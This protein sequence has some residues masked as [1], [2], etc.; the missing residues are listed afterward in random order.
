MGGRRARAR[1]SSLHVAIAGAGIGGLTAA[2]ALARIGCRVAVLEQAAAL[3]EAGA[4][5]QLAPNASRILARLG[6]LDRLGARAVAPERLL[7][8][9][10]SDASVL[11]QMRL[12][13]AAQARW[14]APFL[15]CHR[16]DL[17]TALL[18]AAG[19]AGVMLHLGAALTGL[20][21]DA[22]RVVASFKQGL[23]RQTVEAD[24]LIG[25]DGLH[26]FVR[27]RLAPGSA[28]PVSTRTAWRTLVPAADAPFFARALQSHL[29]LGRQAHLVHYPVR[30]GALV[31]V[32]AIVGE[33]GDAGDARGFWEQKGETFPAARF[34]GWHAGARDLLAAAAAWRKWPLFERPPLP[35]WNA[36]RVA[37]LGDAAHPMLPFLAQGA[38]Q[39]IE[40][41]AALAA[42]LGASRDVEAALAVYSRARSVRADRVQ[43]QSRRQGD[44]YHMAGPAALV[45]NLVLRLTGPERMAAQTD[46]LYARDAGM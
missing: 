7:I 20:A 9:K 17:Q 29:W 15:V 45:R 19:E 24:A 46:W 33:K 44:I 27:A 13:A 36:G 34:A 42:A 26:S 43:A 28:A 12:G 14:G 22:G 31:N 21:A 32:V 39:A 25:A 11:A 40:D 8:H 16:A 10:A 1:V 18:A 3:E 30:G 38:G 37:L 35:H 4:G 2:L 23:V 5:V 6:V 41:A